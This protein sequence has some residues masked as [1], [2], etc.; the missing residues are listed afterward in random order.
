MIVSRGFLDYVRQFSTKG[1]LG[2]ASGSLP[3][4]CAASAELLV[5]SDIDR[6]TQESDIGIH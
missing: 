3:P 4:G 6:A 5:G 1:L 2:Q